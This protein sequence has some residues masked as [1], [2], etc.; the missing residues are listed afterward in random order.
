MFNFSDTFIVCSSLLKF[1]SAVTLCH[2]GVL[3]GLGKWVKH[4]YIE[5]GSCPVSSPDVLCNNIE[6]STIFSVGGSV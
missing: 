5:E 1:I 3:V 6:A 4:S 2:G